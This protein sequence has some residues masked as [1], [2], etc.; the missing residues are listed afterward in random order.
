[1]TKSEVAI[2][3]AYTGI[4]L[5]GMLNLVKYLSKLEGRPIFDIEAPV[6][7]EKHKAKI[8]EDF[9]SINVEDK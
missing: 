4:L 9:K 3:S 2:V 5:G 8:K 6:I 1:M 7:A